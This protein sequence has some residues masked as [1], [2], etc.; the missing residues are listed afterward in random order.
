MRKMSKKLPMTIGLLII[1]ALAYFYWPGT[2]GGEVKP[3]RSSVQSVRS[4]IAEQRTV[5]LTVQANGYVSAFNTVEVRPQVQ[6]IVRE[7]HVKEGQEVRSGQLLFTLDQRSDRSNVDKAR[8]QMARDRADLAEAENALKRNQELFAKNFVSQAVVDTARARVEGL[9]GTQQ[10][11]Q[12]E[13]QASSVALGFNQI[14]ASINGRIGAISVHPGSLAQPG[15]VPMLTIS[16]IDPITVTFSVPERELGY[17]VATYPKGD[18]PVTAKLAGGREIK[19][20]LIFIDNTSNTQ[21]GTIM[22]KAQ[23]SNQDRSLWPGSFVGV[24]LV[25]RSIDNAIVVPAQAI[26]TGPTDK[27]VYLVQD[28]DSV[29]LQKVEVLAIEQQQAII[30]GIPAGV[31][32]VTEGTQNLRPGVKVKEVQGAAG[33]KPT[34]QALGQTGTAQDAAK[35]SAPK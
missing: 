25:T 19:G 12:A 17:I 10:F 18:A 14:R 24:S 3:S 4:T 30:T 27:I 28:D 15:G 31:R 26:V 7:V 29:K 16:Q 20:Q 23:F 21:S 32:V 11:N 13:L 6:N 5:P 9:R 2:S 22:M 33:E 35:S 1:G 34:Q 8:A